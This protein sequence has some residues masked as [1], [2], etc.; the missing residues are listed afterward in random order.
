MIKDSKKYAATGGW[1]YSSFGKDRKPT[2]AASMQSCFP[3]HKAIKSR[4]YVFTLYSP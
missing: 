3:C 2:G 4:D 1:G